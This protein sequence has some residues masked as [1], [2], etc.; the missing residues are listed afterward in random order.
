MRRSFTIILVTITMAAVGTAA[1]ANSSHLPEAERIA[2]EALA[3][4]RISEAS[5]PG[6]SISIVR[7]GAIA[8]AGGFGTIAP[9][10]NKPASADT[11]YRIAGVAQPIT[12]VGILQLV[13]RK[14]SV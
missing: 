7:D 2:V 12:A 11:M 5:I 9:G 10:T 3:R 14:N 6:L 13:E 1:A 8:Y 4:K